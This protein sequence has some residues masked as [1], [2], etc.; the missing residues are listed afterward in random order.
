MRHFPLTTV[1]LCVLLPPL[2]YAFS[3]QSLEKL[4][5]SHYAEQWVQIYT[6]DPQRLFEGSIRL[7]DAIRE[8]TDAFLASRKLPRWG[9]HVWATVKSPDGTVLYP[10]AY[11]TASV[12]LDD[13][14]SIAIARENFRLLNEGL[15][16]TID[17]KIEHNTPISNLILSLYLA[18]ALLVLIWVYRRWAVRTRAEALAKQKVID[19]LSTARQ[20]SLAQLERLQVQRNLLDDK[21]KALQAERLREHQAATDA[22]DQ[23]IDELVA[24]EE[25]IAAYVERHDIQAQE[26]D[27]LKRKILEYE[28]DGADQVGRPHKTVKG[29]RKRFNTLYK[30]T[31]IH[32]RA[33]AG[34][35]NLTEEMKIKAEEVVH[36]LNANPTLVSIKR[37]VFGKKNRQTVF[38]VIF[39]YKGRLYF[40]NGGSNRVEVLVIG[41]KLTQNKDLA[42]LEKL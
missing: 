42:F 27:A 30:D 20:E 33:I 1:I 8:T 18:V 37:K 36:Q 3:V 23:L 2:M 5:R 39:G 26:I 10:G 24:L 19:H 7:Q 40:R 11:D 15:I 35:V 9:V 32:D 22:D 14:D 34:F 13:A 41:T 17:L 16:R 38:E 12:D 25:K 28:K 6:A 31:S 4:V 29:V 21:I